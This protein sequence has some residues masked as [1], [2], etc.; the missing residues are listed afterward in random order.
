MVR[1]P[2]PVDLVRP[3]AVNVHTAVHVH[4]VGR[5]DGHPV[6][7]HGF[8]QSRGQFPPR[9]R[10]QREMPDVVQYIAD[11]RGVRALVWTVVLAPANVDVPI[12][13]GQAETAARFW[14]SVLGVRV[15]VVL[16]PC[17]A[18]VG[19]GMNDV[20]RLCPPQSPTSENVETERKKI[21]I[22]NFWLEMCVL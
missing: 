6:K 4:V 12:K 21:N 16:C 10:V 19:V 18:C 17:V 9:E 3:L 15:G 22:I 7:V 1:Q 14:R 11:L 8:G 20:N 2:V 5:R 13:L